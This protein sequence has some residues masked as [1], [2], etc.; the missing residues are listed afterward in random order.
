MESAPRRLLEPLGNS[1]DGRGDE[2]DLESEYEIREVL[3]QQEKPISVGAPN[4][5]ADKSP[6][7]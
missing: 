3:D 6:C 5:P 4:E 1:D 2:N 7:F